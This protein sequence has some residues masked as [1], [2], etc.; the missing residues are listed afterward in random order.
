MS[1][2]LDTD[3]VSYAM[4]G[5]GG[6]AERLLLHRPSAVAV[7]AIT[8]A[9]LRFGADRK[10]SKRL[11]GLIDAFISPL[12][13]APFDVAAAAAYGRLGHLLAERGQPI[14]DFDVLIAAHALVL[15]RVLVTNNL[16]HF[17]R[18]PG[19]AVESWVED[20]A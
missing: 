10:R 5:Q 4:R 13:V 14:G 16:R 18:V 8:V 9:E 3:T 7:S 2:L 11:H 15:K 12:Q 1:Y 20:G 17:S 6:V 19:L